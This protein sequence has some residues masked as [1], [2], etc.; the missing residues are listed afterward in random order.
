MVN[1][2]TS[3]ALSLL[4]G[5][6]ACVIWNP[7]SALAQEASSMQELSRQVLG[8]NFE[9]DNSLTI[10][11]HSS[12]VES[13]RQSVKPV[14]G[15]LIDE[16]VRRRPGAALQ[17]S[18]GKPGSKT[19]QLIIPV[20]TGLEFV[21]IQQIEPGAKILEIDGRVFVLVR[22]TAQAFPAYQR[23]KQLQE[24]FG[25]AFE[26]AYSDGHP[27]LNLAWMGALNSDLAAQPKPAA[28]PL[29]VVKSPKPVEAPRPGKA[30]DLGL[31]SLVAPWR[32]EP[33]EAKPVVQAPGPVSQPQ[34]ASLAVAP[35]AVLKP[36]IAKLEP[37]DPVQ[38]PALTALVEQKP[39]TTSTPAEPQPA[40][41]VVAPLAVVQPPIAP[42][43][44]SEP[45]QQRVAAEPSNASLTRTSLRDVLSELRRMKASP[46]SVVTEVP[47]ATKPVM[48]AAAPVQ[49][50]PAV[51]RSLVQAVA[52]RPT[53]LGDTPIVSSRFMAVNQDLAYL[54]V[55]V[56]NS[57]D[58]IAV[59]K[60]APITVVHDRNGELL[61]RVG[62][63]TQSRAGER[64]R[65]QQL[66][67]LRQ[68]G[69]QIELIAARPSGSSTD[70]A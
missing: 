45:V 10:D 28:Q 11:G 65:D 64:M 1:L 40:P 51:A 60:V 14:V 54:F 8:T 39:S 3:L 59:R 21:Q 37:T 19:V 24:K 48:A 55:K 27:D 41:L 68:S 29:A 15:N 12:L 56:R 6:G 26:L 44:P 23:G 43:E 61:A 4:A 66:R 38:Q 52:I 49:Q 18:G 63:Y 17:P 58:L 36:S 69:Y 5:C 9:V 31:L 20:K 32:A 7:S 57:D 46:T 13:G 34:P 42:T 22:E 30:H 16:E 62:V 35:V 2:R 50:Q 70:H 25:Y 53:H 33:A 67:T 47:L